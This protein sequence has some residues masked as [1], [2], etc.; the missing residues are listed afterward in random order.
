M[1]Q[2]NAKE[3]K[4]RKA[5]RKGYAKVVK[6]ETSCCTHT[7]FTSAELSKRIGYSQKEIDS[8]PEGA[9]LG[10]GCGNPLALIEAAGFEQVKILEETHFPIEDMINDPTAQAI[11]KSSKISR[12][13]ARKLASTVASIKVSG[14]KP[15]S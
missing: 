14:I 15:K 6:R 13:Q 4:L 10:L 3:D 11:M 1:T 9:N 2:G 8:A 5:V 7:S 12:Q